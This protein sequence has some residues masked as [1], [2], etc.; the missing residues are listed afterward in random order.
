MHQKL[1]SGDIEATCGELLQT[2]RRV[3]VRMV[4][5]ELRRRHNACGKSARVARILRDLAERAAVPSYEGSAE[6]E[7]D[8]LRR[9][10]AQA[11]ERAEK[12]ESRALLSEER[13]RAHQDHWARRYAEKVDEL[14]RQ[15]AALV[16][17]H[18]QAIADAQM[19]LRQQ[20]AW[21]ER[22]NA[23]LS[24]RLSDPETP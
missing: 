16:R 15:R 10:L 13:E 4:T 19:R 20:V 17:A 6:E 23:L 9:E 14:D 22:E 8:R 12:A 2:H 24:R 1:S 5:G 18:E 21:L 11:S 7:V 3:T